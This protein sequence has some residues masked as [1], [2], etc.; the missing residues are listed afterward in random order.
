MQV[1]YQKK[2]REKNKERLKE[3]NKLWREKNKEKSRQYAREWYLKNKEKVSKYHKDAYKKHGVK[4]KKTRARHYQENKERYHERRRINSKKY[5]LNPKNKI[6][7]SIRSGIWHFV[8]QGGKK[9]YKSIYY[10]GC[11]Y[12]FFI[13]YISGKFKE[14]MTLD[15]YGKVW[16]IDHIV[17]LSSFK[18]LDDIDIRTCC[19]YTNLQPL[20][21]KENISKSNKILRPTQIKIP[22]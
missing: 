22:V 12:D 4:W 8:K 6:I 14:G 20:F 3:L 7:S 13:K 18:K 21:S 16:H 10:L 11:D 9:K 5:R 19:H 15:N 1:D 2:Y 17:P